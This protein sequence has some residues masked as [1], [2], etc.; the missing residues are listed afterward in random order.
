MSITSVKMVELVLFYMVM[1]FK[2]GLSFWKD[3]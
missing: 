1:G 3:I 2:L